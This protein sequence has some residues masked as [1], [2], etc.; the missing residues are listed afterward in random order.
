MPR[1][2]QGVAAR[3]PDAITLAVAPR[4]CFS[5]PFIETIAI[6]PDQRLHPRHNHC[7]RWRNARRDAMLGSWLTK[8]RAAM[9]SDHW[10]VSGLRS[11]LAGGLSREGPSV[12]GA[13]P[14][15]RPASASDLR[16]PANGIARDAH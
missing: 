15:R 8:D 7:W 11:P 1:S 16:R 12:D 3:T 5:R 9:L 13:K 4:P 10:Q 2:G 14:T 6:N